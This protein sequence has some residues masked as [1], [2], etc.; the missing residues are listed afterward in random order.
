MVHQTMNSS[1]ANASI[2]SISN[3]A[4]H[5]FCSRARRAVAAWPL[6]LLAACSTPVVT[7]PPP[8]ASNTPTAT[9]TGPGPAAA[10]ARPAMPPPAQ[11]AGVRWVRAD[12]ADLP[13]WTQDRQAELWPALTR[14]C[15]RPAVA[16]RAWCAQATAQRPADDAQARAMLQASLQPWQLQAADGRAD[17][18]ATGYFDPELVASRDRREGFTVPLHAP[19]ADLRSRRPHFSRQE[20]DTVPV[21]QAA[22]AGREIAWIGDAVDLL[23]VQIQGSGRLRIPEADGRTSTLRL[24]FAGHNAHAYRSPGRWLLDQGELRGDTV[25]WGAIRAWALKNPQRVQELL[26]SNP[27]VVFF[28]LEPLPDPSTGPRGAQGVPLTPMR[29]VA[30]DPRAVPYGSPMWI[31]THDPVRAGP[32]QRAVMAQ[33]TGAAIVGAVRIDLFTGWGDEALV[34]ASRM[35]QPLQAWVLWPRGM[36]PPAD[37]L[38]P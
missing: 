32:L 21:A 27:R 15:Q 3:R 10:A 20:L 6:A 35:R 8:V 5:G 36:E 37:L 14:G 22:L 2:A 26:W 38:R 34:L 19:P 31:A 33:D 17:G 23:L 9:A 11:W 25:S 30:V 13:G 7:P 24:A 4:M 28:R 18:L 16:W 29:S 1:N 12:Y